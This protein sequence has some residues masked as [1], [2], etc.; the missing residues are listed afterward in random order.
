MAAAA[1]GRFLPTLSLR[2]G[3]RVHRINNLWKLT[4]IL[5]RCNGALETYLYIHYGSIHFLKK[6]ISL[7]N[8]EDENIDDDGGGGGGNGNDGIRSER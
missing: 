1:A 2:Y 3:D 5:L 7:F 6:R 4:L 8:N